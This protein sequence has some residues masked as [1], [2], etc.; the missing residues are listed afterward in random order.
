[1]ELS[2]QG[3]A[4]PEWRAATGR[5]LVAAQPGQYFDLRNMSENE[6]KPDAV[7]R[8]DQTLWMKER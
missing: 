5:P 3:V 2:R 1:L 8:C 6:F 7:A 4:L